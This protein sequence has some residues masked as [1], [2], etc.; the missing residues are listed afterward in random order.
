MIAPK[1]IAVT[2]CTHWLDALSDHADEPG[3]VDKRSK[4]QN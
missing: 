1:E 4:R 2:S 3:G